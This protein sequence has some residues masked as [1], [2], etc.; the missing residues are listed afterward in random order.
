MMLRWSVFTLVLFVAT[1]DN[2]QGDRPIDFDTEVMPTF[3]RQGCNAGSCH[4]AAIGRGGFKLS[5]L[6]SNSKLDHDAIIRHLEGR[7]VNLKRPDRSLLLLKPSEQVGHEGGLAMSDDSPSYERVHQ[8]ISEGAY[9]S[10]LRQLVK[11]TVS[12]RKSTLP[13]PESSVSVR[14]K[15]TFNDGSTTDVTR[16]TV[17]QAADPDAVSIDAEKGTMTVHRRGAQVVIARFLNQVLPIRLTVPM[18][19]QEPQAGARLTENNPID[20]FINTQLHR[21]RL[22]AS[23]AANDWV[24]LR[25]VTLD[26]TG[27]LPSAEAAIQ[28]VA[29]TSDDKRQQTINAL[30]QS[31]AFSEYWALKWAN[32]LGIDSKQLQPQGARAYHHWFKQQ[33]QLDTAWDQ[34]VVEMLTKS[35]DSFENGAV[36]FLRSAGNPG[37]LAERTSR[38]FMGVRLQCANCHDHPL[39][40]WQQDDYHGLAAIFAKLNRQRIVEVS[41]RGE[42][43][44]PVTGQAAI[45]RIPGQRFLTNTK[46]GRTELADWLTSPQNPYFAKAMV[47][48]IWLHLMGRGLVDPVDDLRTTNPATHPELLQWLA[49]DFANNG[50]RIQ[51]TIKTICNSA[52]YSRDSAPIPGNETDVIFY[53]HALTKP[54][55]AEVI[56]DA[57]TDITGIPLQFNHTDL[58]RTVTLTDN[59]ML[60]PSLDVLGRCDRES[61]CSQAETSASLARSLHLINGELINQRL[62][63][64]NGRLARLMR[65]STS[66]QALLD[67]IFLETLTQPSVSAQTYWQKELNKLEGAAPAA[68]KAF[69]EDVLWGLLTSRAF[70]ANR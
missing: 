5:L 7:R 38:A 15:A 37:E 42:V 61:A 44:H 33:L 41:E 51:H 63:T 69:F 18:Q 25:R 16:W 13:R 23:P 31:E 32:D 55:E 12:P 64:A 50:F 27:R 60:I 10:G 58:P 67:L 39:D 6:G 9:R 57:I 4:G 17:F 54:L 52:T 65:Q 53:S 24:F 59:R 36:N 22:P 19:D 11:L 68:Q 43:T 46:D 35:G 70:M 14:V 1:I 30:L 8:W 62:T 56:A 40:H 20:Q 29:N 48:R 21:L 28:Y 66:N 34:M 49:D 2:A 47:N 26:L 3:T 45:P